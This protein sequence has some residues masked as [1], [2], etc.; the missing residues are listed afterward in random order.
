M[1]GP[2]LWEDTSQREQGPLKDSG[3]S[4]PLCWVQL[5]AVLED[6]A[7]LTST[8]RDGLPG[9]ILSQGTLDPWARLCLCWTVQSA[10][11]GPTGRRNS[12]HPGSSVCFG[13]RSVIYSREHFYVFH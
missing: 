12:L 1:W 3:L 9:S 13:A 8:C 7:W 4:A 10:W 2:A 6:T 11:A 5:A